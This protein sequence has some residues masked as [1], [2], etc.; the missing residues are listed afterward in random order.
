MINFRTVLD[1]VFLLFI[2]SVRNI[3][4]YSQRSSYMI[5][6]LI[7]VQIILLVFTANSLTFANNVNDIFSPY[8]GKLVIVEKGTTFLEGYPANSYIQYSIYTNLT[9]NPAIAEAVGAYYEQDGSNLQSQL[10]L[11]ITTSMES[12]ISPYQY[13]TGI[14]LNNGNFP[15][16]G[17]NQI[18]IG[19]NTKIYQDGYTV[20]NTVKLRNTVNTVITG[21]FIV[22]NVIQSRLVLMPINLLQN[23]TQIYN[24]VSMVVV[25][26]KEGV[27]VS[28]LKNSIENQYQQVD[29]LDNQAIKT[30]T[31]DILGIVDNYTSMVAVIS[32]IVGTLFIL[33]LTNF[34]LIERHF[35]LGLIESIG[36]SKRQ[37]LNSVILENFSLNILAFIPGS[38]LSFIILTIWNSSS[39]NSIKLVNSITPQILTIVFVISSLMILVGSYFGSYKVKTRSIV[40]LMRSI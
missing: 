11:G 2:L 18:A 9:Q 16:F 26:P 31:S 36:M 39:L 4:K 22:N 35:E 29:V 5:L 14:S 1:S 33:I 34:T 17:T 15:Q 28:Q 20:G 12:E 37:I 27:S 32:F 24:V 3:R 30:A 21:L 38:T 25:T 19:S 40:E 13:L 23:I 6:A 8:S 10:F 7:L